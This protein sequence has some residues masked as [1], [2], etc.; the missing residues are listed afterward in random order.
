MFQFEVARGSGGAAMK[1]EKQF[2]IEMVTLDF[3][4]L[5]K[6]RI[7]L[8]SRVIVSGNNFGCINLDL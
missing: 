2:N 4:D 8:S 7:S 1:R 5:M 6:N 3:I